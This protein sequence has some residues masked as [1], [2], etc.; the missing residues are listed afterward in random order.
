MMLAMIL[1][2]LFTVTAI[3]TGLSLIDS[4]IRGSSAYGV[5]RREQ[6]L[7]DAGF[8]PAVEARDTRL[9]RPASS[10]PRRTVA[11]AMRSHGRKRALASLQLAG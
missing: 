8:V 11:S 2:A 4:W 6:A 9:R 7:L 3:A 10:Q 1:T 5:L